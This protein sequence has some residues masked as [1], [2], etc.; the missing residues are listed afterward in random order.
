MQGGLR[1]HASRDQV[2]L[3]RLVMYMLSFWQLWWSIVTPVELI[4]E[5][6]LITPESVVM[7][8]YI[9]YVYSFLSWFNI[10]DREP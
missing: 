1:W 7:N 9:S 6:K 4:M 2:I 3:D 8:P 10:R 5:A